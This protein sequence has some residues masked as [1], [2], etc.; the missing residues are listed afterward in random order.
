MKTIFPA[1]PYGKATSEEKNL[2]ERMKAPIFLKIV[3]AI[4]TM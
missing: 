2:Q 3:S 4:E 1:R